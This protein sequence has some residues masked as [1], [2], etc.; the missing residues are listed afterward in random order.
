MEG[1][2]KQLKVSLIIEIVFGSI[3]SIFMALFLG[4][5]ATDSP[6]STYIDLAI[7]AAIGF[8]IIFLPTV[9]LPYFGIKELKKFE[10]K[11]AII[12]N[13][14][15]SIV[16]LLFVFPPLAFWQFYVLYKLKKA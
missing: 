5:M 16:V 3:L 10:H 4:T 2:I 9:L 14:I 1:K 7:G 6:S 8:L 11:K 12:I 13:S 15:N